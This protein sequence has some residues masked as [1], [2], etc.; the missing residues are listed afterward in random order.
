MPTV[1]DT[2]FTGNNHGRGTLGRQSPL[3]FGHVGF[4]KA[5]GDNEGDFLAAKTL[6]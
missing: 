6:L 4:L 1:N 3:G 5:I 2:N